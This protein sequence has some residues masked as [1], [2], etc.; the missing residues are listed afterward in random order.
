MSANDLTAEKT[1]L[2]FRES[3]PLGLFIGFCFGLMSFLVLGKHVI[4]GDFDDTGFLVIIWV[5]STMIAIIFG[6]G[7]PSFV[8]LTSNIAKIAF[9][10]DYS[11]KV[12]LGLI[13]AIIM[14][15]FGVMINLADDKTGLSKMI[16]DMQNM[17]TEA[18]AETQIQ[19]PKPSPL[20]I[21][22]PE[23]PKP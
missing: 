4:W 16:C 3:V 11:P 22:T 5:M 18:K 10:P 9:N 6:I 19:F 21:P 13:I 17:M 14:N 12:K 7:K 2:H 8:K 20:P 23:P 15:L 1:G